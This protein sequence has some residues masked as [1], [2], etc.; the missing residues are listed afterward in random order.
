MSDLQIYT[1]VHEEEY[2][3]QK[4]KRQITKL[5]HDEGFYRYRLG[6]PDYV[7]TIKDIGPKIQIKINLLNHENDSR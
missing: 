7:E 5:M 6:P 4:L 1:L 3:E 2:S